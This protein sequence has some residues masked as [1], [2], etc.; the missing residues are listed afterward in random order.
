MP[1]SQKTFEDISRTWDIEL[2]TE[3]AAAKDVKASEPADNKIKNW[4]I[5]TEDFLGTDL[6]G[7]TNDWD[8][9][10]GNE[11]QADDNWTVPNQEP[12]KNPLQ[13]LQQQL[14]LQREYEKYR[15]NV[16][17]LNV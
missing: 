2:A 11:E 4:D 8:T 17:F 14:R 6:V 9:P 7:Y 15:K 5:L 16:L 3:A 13:Q 10:Y 1:V 12:W